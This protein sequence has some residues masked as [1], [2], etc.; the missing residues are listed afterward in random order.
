MELFADRLAFAGFTLYACFAPHS[1]AGAEIS[2]ALVAIAFL[3]RFFSKQSIRISPSKVDLPIILFLVFTVCS[4]FLSEEPRISIA[5]LQSVCVVFLLYLGRMFLTRRSI[6]FLVSL[7]IASGVAGSVWSVA[8]RVIGRGVVVENIAPD[9]PF[10]DSEVAIGDA[11]WRLGGVK[12]SSV[13]EVNDVIARTPVGMRL[14]VSVIRAGEHADFPGF[15]V[16]ESDNSRTNPSGITGDHPTHKFRASGWTRH[17]ETFSETLQILAQL[18]LGFSLAGFRRRTTNR[19]DK[20]ALGAAAILMVGIALTAMR[21]VLVATILGAGMVAWR[22]AD[23][24]LRLLSAATLALVCIIGVFAVYHTRSS[25]SI[26]LQDDSSTLRREVAQAGLARILIH[27]FF[28]VGMDSVHLHWR[29]WGFPGDVII[30]THSTPLELAFERGIPALFFWCWILIAFWRITSAA[31]HRLRDSEPVSNH[32]FVLGALGSITG[33]VASSLVN[34]NFG[35]GEVALVFWFL[36]G[37]VIVI[38]QK[39]QT[40]TE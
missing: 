11:I 34:Y 32:G 35:D 17:Y 36:M 37:A 12:V 2:L 6:V 24:R 40:V 28:G 20:I 14:G 26:V 1:I 4:S 22:S 23:R 18:A 25:G 3:I 5:K 30:H 29:D 9:S 7:M 19:L 15:V 16:S 10:K 8:E 13:H 31:E 33:F 27:P 21:T 38:S 39:N